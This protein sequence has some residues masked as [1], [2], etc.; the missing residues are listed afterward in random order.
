MR[1]RPAGDLDG[2]DDSRSTEP[3]WPGAAAASG[4]PPI[5]LASPPPPCPVV[6]VPP[7]FF[8]PPSMSALRSATRFI[9]TPV[10]PATLRGSVPLAQ[11]ALNMNLAPRHDDHHG[12]TAGSRVGTPRPFALKFGRGSSTIGVNGQSQTPSTATCWR[13]GRGGGKAE[14]EGQQEGRIE[15][16]PAERR[17]GRLA[18]LAAVLA[19]PRK[20]R[21]AQAQRFASPARGGCRSLQA[22]RAA[23]RRVAVVAG[24]RGGIGRS[25]RRLSRHA[26]VQ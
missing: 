8:L 11:K 25:S 13:V 26:V 6:V 20:S 9:N 1:R 24:R 21:L 22:G 2:I 19:R 15:A 18:S 4:R 5:R 16:S 7:S 23:S 3:C 10:A 14:G 17:R 12:P